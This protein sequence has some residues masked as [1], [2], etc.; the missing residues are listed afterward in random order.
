MFS[1]F[2]AP[3]TLAVLSTSLWAIEPFEIKDGD[4]VLLLGDAL[5]ERE[6]NYG[7][8]ET[9]MH[10]EFRDRQFTVRN[11]SW[12]GE[13]PR[14]WSR[15]S[16][17]APAKGYERL[18]EQIA[19]VKPTVV[20]LGF[21]MAASLQEMT[22][23]SG[24]IMLN[25]DPVRYG[26]EPM[27]AAR[28]KTEL[29]E[30]MDAI[31]AQSA[32]EA[33]EGEK[34]RSPRFVLLSPIRHE[35]LRN[36][37]PAMPNPADHNQ[38]LT[39]YSKVMAEL[40]LERGARFVDYFGA[41]SKA[42]PESP[43]YLAEQVP[44]GIN[45][46]ET[47][48]QHWALAVGTL[49]GW[50]TGEWPKTKAELESWNKTHSTFQ[51]SLRAKVTRKNEL[52]F[53]RFRPANGTYLF[54]FRKHEQG[55]NAKEIPAFDPLIAQF[56]T[57]IAQ[58]KQAPAKVGEAEIPPAPAKDN[59]LANVQPQP[60][61]DF[62]VAEGYQIELWAQNPLLEKPTQMNWDPKGRLWVTSSSLYPQIEPGGLADDKIL[63]LEDTDGDGKAD[64]STTF[65]DELLIPTGVAPDLMPCQI[66]R[67]KAK[68][69][70]KAMPAAQPAAC[71]VGQSTELLHF[72]DTD[73]DG[74]ADKKHIV[75]SGFGTEDTHHLIHTLRWGPDGRL[76]FNSSIYIHSHV[77]TPWGMVRLNS[78]G[79]FAYDPRTER[80][81]V[82]FKGLIN[83]WG[84]AWN[85]W[86]QSFLTDGAGGGGINWGI[87]GAMQVTYE[88]ARRILPSVS[89]GSYPKFCGL[90]I[91]KSPHFPEDWQGNAITCDFRA[92]RI[93]R[94]AMDDLSVTSDPPKSGFVT[95]DMPDIVRTNDLSFRPID[96]RHGPD[97]ALYIADWSNPVINH[98][99]VDFRDPRRD[100]H[101]G[102]IWRVT[103]KGAPAVKWESLSEKKNFDLM[104]R[105][106]SPNAWEEEQAGH[107]LHTRGTVELND[108]NSAARAAR[109]VVLKDDPDSVLTSLESWLQQ[110]RTA[111]RLREVVMLEASLTLYSRAHLIEMTKSPEAN[112][113]ALISRIMADANSRGPDVPWTPA[114]PLKAAQPGT[115]PKKRP[116][117]LTLLPDLANDPHPRVRLEA[118]RALGRIHS[119]RSAE[120]A[121][122]AAVRAP[123]GDQYY[124]YA[125]WLTVNDLARPWTA[126][127][128]NG[129][130]KTEGNEAQLAWGLK[131][132]D[133]GLAGATLSRLFLE[134]KVPLDGAGPWLELL[135]AAGG[136]EELQPLWDRLLAAYV[137]DCCETDETRALAQSV[138]QFKP[139]V[140]P[141]AMT[142]LLEAARI[143]NVKPA[144]RT[145]LATALFLSSEPFRSGAVE[146]AGLWKVAGTAEKSAELLASGN[147]SPSL[148]RTVF[149]SLRSL[150]NAESKALLVKYVEP[151]QPL[152]VRRD[153]VV[154][155]A[156]LDLNKASEW[157][158]E[159]LEEQKEENA[160]LG[161]WR[162]LL[163]IKGAADRLADKITPQ[164]PAPVASTGVR[165]ARE[166]GKSGA[167]LLAALAP[168][169][170]VQTTEAPKDFKEI[171]SRVKQSG[172]P[173]RGEFVYRRA[174]LA[175]VTCHSI[176]GAGGKV[177]PDM[178]S[179]GASAPLDYVIE[180]V[181]APAVK[182][183]EGYHAVA[184]ALAD[185]TSVAGVVARETAQEVFVRNV[186][187][188][189][190]KVAKAQITGK[191]DVGSI[192]PAG[193][194]D[195][196]KEREQ[197]DLY[198]FLG[199][200]GK[201]G[202]YDASKGTVA[203]LWRLYPGSAAEAVVS[204]N[205]D[206][207][208]NP[209]MPGYTLVDGRMV[210]ELMAE[211]V[212][213]AAGGGDTVLAVAQFQSNGVTRLN[214]TG[215]TKAWLDNKPL[216]LDG[217]VAPELPAGVHTLVVKLDVKQLPPVLKAESPDARF[218]GN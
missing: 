38:L 162:E 62:Q 44:N 65:T 14:G 208:A 190:Q 84:H 214:L 9:Q 27:T 172:D 41:A 142:A 79:V 30:L 201:P 23:R 76:Y 42:R 211:A 186:V 135:G 195:Q 131:A 12:S 63:L 78:G 104:D 126:A 206:P 198:A 163:A 209:G 150:G 146:L 111:R 137:G 176:G 168:L 115:T 149:R 147:V 175:C 40:A 204:P 166:A 17:D 66:T 169:A 48:Y 46:S 95:R 101:L 164:V 96:V 28:F 193:L 31:G 107:L 8:L 141:R 3:L 57:E 92:H 207:A 156:A 110:D 70:G 26:R 98:G 21:G 1:R 152:E 99:E 93:V 119:A 217:N 18:K 103:R 199:E 129:E 100:K 54:G 88:G 58:I 215:V 13:T 77:E 47:G 51:P 91:V 182:V 184:F 194:V 60:A 85:E 52:F 112:N 81:E 72:A 181:L 22:D 75:F 105:L 157:L 37:R 16:F 90:E 24:D 161:L 171:A 64:K 144:A 158:F 49:L 20:F 71:Y 139:A 187:G 19:E 185:G 210:T 53:H 74:R 120:L 43:D 138:Q 109:T 124:D 94:F 155:L 2:L 216:V 67:T 167:K 133:P 123:E 128:A 173:A 189:E 50:S 89:P 6:G 200:L 33:K 122:E 32:A 177:G 73:G 97:G 196:L 69:E 178:T 56:E 125:A 4:R 151:T 11:L 117:G 212:P 192:M 5:L 108:R 145:E 10:D 170:G 39:Q 35:D 102:R 202:V 188:Q 106:L 140:A 87:P 68:V 82:L 203:R 213:M 191:T 121:L 59:G 61:P 15:A 180:S 25:P 165:A 143:R 205:Y 183:K 148:R 29:A 174:A 132:I 153:A 116:R 118:M 159:I 218:L 179:I 86:G 80:L 127:I 55:Q 134:G 83:P 154:A 7:Y 34:R 130:W 45:L 113:R 114:E 160:T 197:L 36:V 136:P